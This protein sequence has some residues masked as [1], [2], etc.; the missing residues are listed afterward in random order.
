M[1]TLVCLPIAVSD[2]HAALEDAMAARDLGADLVEFRID[3]WFEGLVDQS[4]DA[5]AAVL[6][7]VARC[8]LPSIVTCRPEWE[9]GEYHGDEE[10]R[11]DLFERL[12]GHA[13]GPRYVDI[14]LEAFKRTPELVDRLAGCRRGDG[15]GLIVSMH[16]FEGR[17]ADLSRRLASAYGLGL[18]EVI[19]IAYRARSLRDNLELFEIERGG[20]RPTIALG[21]GRFGLASRVLAP[22]FGGFLTFASLRD[23]AA[24][25]PGQP[26]IA[27]LLGLYRFRSIRP[28]TRVYGVVGWPIEHSMSP[29]IHNAGFEAVGHDGVYLPLPVAGGGGAEDAWA[30]FKAT[31]GAWIDDPTLDFAGASVTLPHKENLVRLAIE[32]GYGLDDLSRAC[33]AGNT[34]VREGDG[35]WSVRNTDG[36]AAVDP[37]DETLGGISGKTVIVLGAG[38]AARAVVFE[39]AMRH[40][41]V[42]VCNRSASRAERLAADANEKLG[43]DIEPVRIGSLDDGLA[44]D[45]LINCTPVG[46]VGG[47]QGSPVTEAQLGSIAGL[48]VVE[49]TVYNPPETPLVKM[50]TNQMATNR[51][52]RA[53]GGVEMFVRQGAAQFQAWTGSPAPSGLFERIVQEELRPKE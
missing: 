53:F 26:T 48:K 31:I 20:H 21:M 10:A 1:P 46:M 40:A 19:K 45:A 17:P 6:D 29:T 22:K 47:P 12:L 33:G 30:S 36:P 34:L 11:L 9:G 18:G 3:A 13:D 5:V 24:T 43:D 44:G 15:C 27:D 4:S 39:L 7:L 49:D 32:R 16:D 25:A 28:S 51:G 37:L 2:V 35:G 8:E 23:S 52:L 41:I 42:I 50:A 38:G 14:E